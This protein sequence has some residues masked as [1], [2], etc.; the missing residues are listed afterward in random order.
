VISRS[1]GSGNAERVDC[2]DWLP[3]ATDITRFLAEH[4]GI[5]RFHKPRY[6][7]QLLRDLATLL[8]G[9]ECRVLDIGAG[10]GL[11]AQ[12]VASLFPGKTVVALDVA[13]RPLPTLRI[14]Y[15]KFDGS[16]LP[17]DD[18]TFDCALFCN[19]LHHV[20]PDLRLGLLNNA[21]R[22]TGGGP[23]VIKDH[24]AE[25]ALDRGRL[26]WLDLVGNLLSGGMVSA[27]Y[28]GR[29]DWEGMFRK[30]RC[31]AEMRIGSPYRTGI[32]SILFPNRL[33]VCFRVTAT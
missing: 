13:P 1:T 16:H 2:P 25:T 26:A 3:D 21:L 33:E 22:V 10:S 6:Q 32:S 4:R 5:Y 19:V 17:F 8:P 24:L 31:E 28:L 14:P 27:V 20:H 23:I 12:A 9:G 29:R 18:S 11:L 30:L 15:Q 7:L